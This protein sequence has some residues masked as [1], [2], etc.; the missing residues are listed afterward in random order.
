M[1]GVSSQFDC[2][3]L[4]AGDNYQVE[5]AG[6]FT[7]EQG[8]LT[9]IHQQPFMLVSDLDDTMIGDDHSTAQFR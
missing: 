6:T 2:L 1:Q 8:N 3:R 5:H 4:C 7:L 9:Q